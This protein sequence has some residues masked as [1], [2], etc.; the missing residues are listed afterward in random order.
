LKSSPHHGRNHRNGVAFK[1]TELE[2]E[3]ELIDSNLDRNYRAGPGRSRLVRPADRN[4]TNSPITNLKMEGNGRTAWS[5]GTNPSEE[6]GRF[7]RIENRSHIHIT[8]HHIHRNKEN[9]NDAPPASAPAH[10][11]YPPTILDLGL[12]FGF[13]LSPNEI[14]TLRLTVSERNLNGSGRKRKKPNE[15][16]ES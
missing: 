8:S 7:V 11:A 16:A 4:E 14:P 6:S 2:L 5:T 10:M 13:K 15:G 1:L 12:E 3:I 9:Q